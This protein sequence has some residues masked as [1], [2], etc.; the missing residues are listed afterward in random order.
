MPN[1]WQ[2][3]RPRGMELW[4]AWAGGRCPCPWEGAETG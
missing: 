1:P 2:C 4:A 3:S